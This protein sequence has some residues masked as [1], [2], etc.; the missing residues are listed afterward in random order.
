LGQFILSQTATTLRT[1]NDALQV[2]L[3]W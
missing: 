2:R 3:V 1:F